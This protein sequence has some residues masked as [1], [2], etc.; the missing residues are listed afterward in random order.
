MTNSVN[1]QCILSQCLVW[2]HKT[3]IKLNGFNWPCIMIIKINRLFQLRMNKEDASWQD[4]KKTTPLIC[5]NRLKSKQSENGKKFLLCY[6]FKI[7]IMFTKIYFGGYVSLNRVLVV[8]RLSFSNTQFS[9][10]LSE[11]WVNW[12]ILYYMGTCR[13]YPLHIYTI[14]SMVYCVKK[15]VRFRFGK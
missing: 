14:K 7:C 2:K 9:L 13:T 15:L 4:E 5:H 12:W 11:R 8:Y 6:V 1:R 10:H 3:E